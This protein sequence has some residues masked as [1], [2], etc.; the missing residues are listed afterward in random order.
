MA[1]RRSGDSAIRTLYG[2][3]IRQ[4]APSLNRLTGIVVC[5]ATFATQA[6]WI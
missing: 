3:P 2:P 4:I 5:L 1:I 6:I